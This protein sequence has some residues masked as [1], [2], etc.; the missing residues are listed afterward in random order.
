MK[1]VLKIMMPILIF[2]FTTPSNANTAMYTEA[3]AS[4]K[5]LIVSKRH[6]KIAVYNNV[7]YYRN[8]GIWYVKKNRRFRKV[9]A[10]IGASVAVLPRNHKTVIIRGVKYYRGGGV[11]YRKKGRKYIVVKI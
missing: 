6:P 7:Q 5:V 10:P 1:N 8:K 3:H 2:C 4:D 9:A 11:Y